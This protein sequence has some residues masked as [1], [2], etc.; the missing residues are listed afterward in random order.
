MPRR[1]I[2]WSISAIVAVALVLSGLAGILLCETALHP[3]RRPVPFNP[4]ARTVQV[5]ARDG[6]PLRAWLFDPDKRNGDAVLILHGIADSRASQVGLAQM[7][8]EHGYTVLAPDSRAHGESGGDL[9]TYGLLE[10]DDVHRWVS[11][12]IDEPLTRGA[13]RPR[14]IF[15]IGESLGGAVLIESLAVETRFSAIVADSAF[16]SF[17]RIAR[18][19]VAERLPFPSKIGRMLA[20]PLVWAGFLYARLRYGLDFRRASPEAAIARSMTPVLLIHG[21]ND[22]QTS[23]EHSKTLFAASRCAT[24][25]LVTGAGHTGAFG[26]APP[27]FERRV[28]DFYQNLPPGIQAREK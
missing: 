14:R 15:S 2:F 20:I 27:E 25:W 24:L 22:Q 11:W 13:Q 7:F 10:S 1:R 9:A 28:L 3:P 18:D 6:I 26:V 19:R 12:L 8:L 5:T 16:S 21:L 4:R 23:P 17:E